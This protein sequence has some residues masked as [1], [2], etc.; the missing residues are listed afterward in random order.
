M[1]APA[2][3]AGLTQALDGMRD[4]GASIWETP[5]TY[6][7][8]PSVGLV[9]EPSGEGTALLVVA[10]GG[11]DA[12]PKYLVRFS[13]VFSVTC[14]EEAG[15][16]LD[17]GQN[18]IPTNVVAHIWD[19]SPQA[20]AY[21]VTAFAADFEVRHYVVFGGDNIASIISGAPPTIEMVAHPTEIVVRC[22]V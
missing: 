11:L 18:S 14:S 16:T 2:Q 12:Y 5:F 1:A 8:F 9:M 3:R 19:A 7:Q 20:A 4:S 13:H 22:A 21:S 6:A 15:F 10:P 17:L